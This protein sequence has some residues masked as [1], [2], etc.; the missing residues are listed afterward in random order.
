VLSVASTASFQAVPYISNLRSEPRRSTCLAEGW[1]RRDEAAWDSRVRVVPGYNND[2]GVPRS[3]R[4]SVRGS[5]GSGTIAETVA[6]NGLKALAAGKSYG[7]AGPGE[8]PLPAARTASGWCQR[9]VVTRI[10][11]KLFRPPD[12]RAETRDL[13]GQ[14]VALVFAR[15]QAAGDR[16]PCWSEYPLKSSEASNPRNENSG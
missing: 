7:S 5:K 15:E 9:R 6:R 8:V 13:K 11:A 1:G 14:L 3:C 10:A 16:L 2:I 4:P 12:E